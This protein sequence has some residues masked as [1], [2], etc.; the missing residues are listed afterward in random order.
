MLIYEV[1]SRD[2]DRIK[3]K[4]DALLM[5]ADDAVDECIDLIHQVRDSLIPHLRAEEAVFYNSL[6]AADIGGTIHPSH[7]ADHQDLEN[8]LHALLITDPSDGG[9][10]ELTLQLKREFNEHRQSEEQELYLAAQELLTDE[11]AISL[12][13]AFERMRP[14]ILKT[15]LSQNTYDAVSLLMPKRFTQTLSYRSH[16]RT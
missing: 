16:S 3:K 7:F 14:R 6:Q 10:R 9:W 4:L 5:L 13:K 8:A 1:L 2:H 11:E 12:G 15:G